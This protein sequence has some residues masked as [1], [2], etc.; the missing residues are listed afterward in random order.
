VEGST[1]ANGGKKE[2]CIVTSDRCHT[3][4]HSM[5]A[6]NDKIIE[7]LVEP[8]VHVVGEIIG[9][10]G[11]DYDNAF[12]KH[13]VKSGNQW[14]CVGGEEKGQSQ[15]D[16]PSN[17][18]EMYVWNQPLDLHFYT[19]TLQGWPKMVFTV[20][21]LDSLG[22][23]TLVGYAFCYVPTE[24]G[25]HEMDVAV[26]RPRGTPK[27]E[28]FDFFL[29]GVP[30]LVNDELVYNANRAKEERCRISTLHQGYIHLR[31]E[32]MLRNMHSNVVASTKK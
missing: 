31:L 9:G 1:E 22:N 32:V 11:F 5:F 25:I 21:R 12:C 20:G 13:E 6:R 24:S 26:W 30:H 15:C 14:V 10:S 18:E 29:G 16:Y 3:H 4:S 27:E 7:Q 2:A 28:V 8:E 19:Q 17:K 23:N